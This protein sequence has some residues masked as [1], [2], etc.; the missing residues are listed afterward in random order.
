MTNAD[1]IKNMTYFELAK[2][3][4]SIG[5]RD[6]EVYINQKW[7]NSFELIEWLQSEA[8]EENFKE[9]EETYGQFK[10]TSN[11]FTCPKCGFKNNKENFNNKCKQCGYRFG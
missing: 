10:Q 4:Y 5:G 1:R 6:G 11:E 9:F 7:M 2:F 8:K 3:L